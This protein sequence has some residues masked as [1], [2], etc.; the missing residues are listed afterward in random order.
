MSASTV[1]REIQAI[2][3]M[4]KLNGY[5]VARPKSLPMEERHVRPYLADELRR[6]F[7]ACASWPPEEPGRY[8]ALFTFLYCTGAR[9]AEVIPSER[10]SH[11]A[12]LKKEIDYEAG[13]VV[14]RSAKRRRGS[15]RSQG[16]LPLPAE[17]LE[18]VRQQAKKTEGP[19]VFAP[20]TLNN[21]FGKIVRQAGLQRV[22]ELG[23]K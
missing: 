9:P 18:L 4:L 23:D 10:S 2:I 21:I 17:V 8:L 22:D 15:R 13:T 14:I 6:F 5:E 19:H 12:L 1:N 7:G 20:M 3:K 16:V 11:V